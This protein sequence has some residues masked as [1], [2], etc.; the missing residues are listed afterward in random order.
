ME[1]LSR[2]FKEQSSSK[3][4]I[5]IAVII[6]MALLLGLIWCCS[7]QSVCVKQCKCLC[8]YYVNDIL[9]L[10]FFL[11]LFLGST[12]AIWKIYTKDSER[13]ERRKEFNRKI[14]LEEFYYKLNKENNDRRFE[15]E[16]KKQL[17]S[18]IKSIAEEF[19]KDNPPTKEEIKE[20][21]KEIEQ[22]KNKKEAHFVVELK[23]D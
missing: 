12:W 22:L 7:K 2:D 11:I 18:D 8:F 5:A 15:F 19:S 20:M 23:K 14:N 16:K 21:K 10:I 6:I 1:N 3:S 17:Y 4:W 13:D 9:N